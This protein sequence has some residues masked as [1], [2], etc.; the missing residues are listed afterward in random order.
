M[1]T[2]F[3]IALL[4]A[5]LFVPRGAAAEYSVVFSGKELK[6]TSPDYDATF[7]HTNG[8]H[9]YGWTLRTLGYRGHP[10][11]VAT[12]ANGSTLNRRGPDDPKSGF[13][14]GSAHG[15]E[16]IKSIAAVVDGKRYEMNAA[17]GVFNVSG[18]LVE[19][20]KRSL[21]GPY[22]FTS[23]VA[24][25]ENGLTEDY[26]FKGIEDDESIKIFYP[27]MHCMS[28]EL[29]QWI[30]FSGSGSRSSGTFRDDNSFTALGAIKW[31]GAYS[32]SGGFGVVVSLAE[33]YEGKGNDANRFWNRRYDRKHY[34]WAHNSHHPSRTAG[35]PFHYI[36][37]LVA[38][39]ETP[40]QWQSKAASIENSLAK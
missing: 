24:L 22:E 20:E 30:A 19:V 18:N 21:I 39:E 12:G 40:G 31:F 15:G 23:R 14:I 32:G 1:S 33:P 35:A 26:S 8:T 10:I 25:D 9:D 29:S 36:S 28:K 13:W 3:K 38:F 11:L 34:F 17:D 7:I 16:Q 2:S 37:R 4:A 6:V 27:F 5:C